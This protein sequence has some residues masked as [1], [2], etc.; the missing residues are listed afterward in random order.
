MPPMASDRN[1]ERHSMPRCEI[2]AMDMPHCVT[3]NI[4]A[5]YRS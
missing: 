5:L 4:K 1:A 3:Q 2:S